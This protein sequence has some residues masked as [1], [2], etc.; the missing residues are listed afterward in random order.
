MTWAFTAVESACHS[1]TIRT[2][3]L[4]H[5][6]DPQDDRPSRPRPPVYG[7]RASRRR[8]GSS[9]APSDHRMRRAPLGDDIFR[10]PCRRYAA[11][12]SRFR[13]IGARG[14]RRRRSVPFACL[15]HCGCHRELS[16]QR[17]ST[18]AP[19]QRAVQDSPFL[20]AWLRTSQQLART[21]TR[22]VRASVADLR[23]SRRSRSW[24]ANRV[25]NGVPNRAQLSPCAATQ[26]E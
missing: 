5:Q 22:P 1:T 26:P 16:C 25:P 7:A 23:R 19:D 12:D 4:R 9:V 15:R 20:Q 17:T 24:D 2:S 21:C 18:E 14:S 6:A 10:N 11:P 3:R 8:S 13:V